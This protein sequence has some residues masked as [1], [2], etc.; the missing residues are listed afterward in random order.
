VLSDANATALSC[1][2]TSSSF[3]GMNLDFTL[4]EEQRRLSYT[5]A[6]FAF[7]VRAN[8]NIRQL[9]SLLCE[10]ATLSD[11]TRNRLDSNRI[12]IYFSSTSSTLVY[13]SPARHPHSSLL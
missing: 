1:V 3:A 11:T 4:L 6:S 5:T 10:D 8:S 2:D 12:H 7:S 13:G 9:Q